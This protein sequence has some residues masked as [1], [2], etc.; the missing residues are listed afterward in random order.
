M[1]DAKVRLDSY[2]DFACLFKTR[3]QA[4]K[5]LE[6]GRVLVNGQRAKGSNTVKPGDT[7]T[8]QQEYGQRIVKVLTVLDRNVPKAQARESYQDLTPPPPEE[9][10]EHRKLDRMLRQMGTPPMRPAK[11]DRRKLRRLKGRE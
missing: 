6:L 8:L 7:L 2:L 4:K 11:G 3:S 1:D 9:V 5:A 10:L